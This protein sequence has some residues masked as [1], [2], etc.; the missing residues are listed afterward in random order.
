MKP[1][2]RRNLPGT[3]VTQDLGEGAW[4]LSRSEPLPID[5]FVRGA[6][7][8]A[9]ETLRPSAVRDVDVEWRAVVCATHCDRVRNECCVHC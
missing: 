8:R 4:R 3:F 7:F 1:N 5:V 2:M 6:D 9:A